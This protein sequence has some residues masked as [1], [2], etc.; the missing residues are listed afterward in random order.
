MPDALR[1]AASSPKESDFDVGS[2]ARGIQIA[3]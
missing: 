3:F 2:L 1:H